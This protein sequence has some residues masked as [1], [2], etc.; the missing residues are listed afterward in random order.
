M[1]TTP[2][3]SRSA[4]WPPATTRPAVNANGTAKPDPSL[5]AL[6]GPSSIMKSPPASGEASKKT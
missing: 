5:S 6:P 3:P 1:P 2:S 4:L